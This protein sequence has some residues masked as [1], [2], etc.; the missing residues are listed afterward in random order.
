[1][2]IKKY[3]VFCCF[4][5]L[6]LTIGVTCK[7]QELQYTIYNDSSNLQTY[8]IKNEMLK[9]YADIVQGVHEESVT[10]LL[11]DNLN[12]FE[13][14]DD[15]HAAWKHDQLELTIGDGKGSVIHGDLDSQ[16]LC[17]PEAKPKSL[18]AEWFQ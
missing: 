8:E 5:L 11:I 6:V 16:G 17:F 2:R 12:V 3:A 7:T 10:R 18:F 14:N 4:W 13:W 9:R 15:M 1:M